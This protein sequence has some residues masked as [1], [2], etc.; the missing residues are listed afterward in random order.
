MSIRV[1]LERLRKN[2]SLTD[3]KVSQKQY[4]HVVNVWKKF[5]MK[6]MNNY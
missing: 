2:S 4:D 1:I 5:E 3:I 6:K